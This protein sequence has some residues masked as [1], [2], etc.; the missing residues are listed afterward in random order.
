VV[1]TNLS[2]D[3]VELAPG[4]QTLDAWQTVVGGRND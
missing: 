4:G 1:V 2:A 3:Q